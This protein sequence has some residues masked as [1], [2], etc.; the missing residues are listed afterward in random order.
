M[1]T[2]QH[3]HCNCPDVDRHELR[4]VVRDGAITLGIV[5]LRLGVG[6]EQC[7]P[8]LS[9]EIARLSRAA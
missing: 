8:E 9:R 6:C 5:R 7:G 3:R 4:R 2:T 1:S